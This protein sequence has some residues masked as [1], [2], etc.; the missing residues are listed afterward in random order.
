FTKPANQCI[1]GNSF[2]FNAGGAFYGTTQIDW[3]FGGSATPS[4]FSGANPT[5]IVFNTIGNKQI[6]IRYRANGCDTSFTD[7][8]EIYVSPYSNFSFSNNNCVDYFIQFSDSSLDSK[9]YYWDFGDSTTLADTSNLANP[10]Y[11]FPDSGTYKVMLVMGSKTSICPDTLYQQVILHPLLSPF[12]IAPMNECLNENSFDF[13]AGGAFY[14]ST[15]IDWDFGITATPIT[16]TVANPTNIV[17]RTSGLKP[18]SIRYSA[19]GCDTS[20]LDTIEVYPSPIADFRI[21]EDEYCLGDSLDSDL[22]SL[23]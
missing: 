2:D 11:T 3:D 9:D 1:D 14:S 8:I 19:F 17:Y 15:Q 5:G 20:Y 21:N 16:S 6:T 4:T 10:S 13:N 23:S 22:V 12:F 18:I 7:S